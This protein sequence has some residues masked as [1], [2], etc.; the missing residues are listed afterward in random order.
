M[1]HIKYTKFN[2]AKLKIYVIY[3][4]NRD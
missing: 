3:D 4:C 1:K 2:N